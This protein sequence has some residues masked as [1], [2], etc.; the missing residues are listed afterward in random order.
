MKNLTAKSK[1]DRER[2]PEK[3][4]EETAMEEP[5]RK[6]PRKIASLDDDEV[7]LLN[8]YVYFFSF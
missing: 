4:K 7:V 5:E 8:L 1:R 3:M 2:Q 6:I